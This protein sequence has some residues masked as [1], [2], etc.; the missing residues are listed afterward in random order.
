MIVKFLLAVAVVAGSVTISLTLQYL[1][2]RHQ[3]KKL[4]AIL[5]VVQPPSFTED[6]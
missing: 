4:R 1:W 3:N 5:G 6:Q 2:Y